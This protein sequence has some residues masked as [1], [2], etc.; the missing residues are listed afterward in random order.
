MTRTPLRR[1][2]RGLGRLVIVLV[3]P[4]LFLLQ[5]SVFLTTQDTHSIDTGTTRGFY[6]ADP[7]PWAHLPVFLLLALLAW[8][9]AARP[10][11]RAP[12]GT[13]WGL[14]GAVCAAL[15]WLVAGCRMQPI[16]DAAEVLRCA[17]ELL[18]GEPSSLGAA[19][20]LNL[21][22]NN[23]F[24]VAYDMAFLRLFGDGGAVAAM[25]LANVLWFAAAVGFFAAAAARLL[26]TPQRAPAF[27]VLFLLFLPMGLYVTFVYG[28][29]PGLALS[30]VQVWA[31]AHCLNEDGAAAAPGWYAA[32]AV[33]G[34]L[35][36][37]CKQNY[38][39]LSV[40]VGLYLLW[41]ALRGGPRRA[42]APLAAL[43]ALCVL[44]AGGSA[45]TQSAFYA[46][47]GLAPGGGKPVSSWLALGM[48]DIDASE[49]WIGAQEGQAVA[50]L[51]AEQGKAAADAYCRAAIAE[52]LNEFRQDPGLAL[53]FYARKTTSQWNM[54][55]FQSLEGSHD[56]VM[57]PR[58]VRWAE[59]LL[60]VGG[61]LEPLYRALADLA[62]TQLWAWAL[63][64]LV[65]LYRDPRPEQLF[66]YIVFLGGFLFHLVWEAKAQYTVVY[67]FLLLPCAWQGLCAFGRAAADAQ[68]HKPG[69][70]AL[71]RRLWPAAAVPALLLLSGI[72]GQYVSCTRAEAKAQAA[73]YAVWRAEQTP[74]LPEGAHRLLRAA[75][76]ATLSI[77]TADP[78]THLQI[79]GPGTVFW[80]VPLHARLL[81]DSVPQ[82]AACQLLLDPEGA[83]A[84]GMG[85]YEGTVFANQK[86]DPDPNLWP[87]QWLLRDLGGDEWALYI[88]DTDG[89][90]LA[91]T[92]AGEG[93]VTLAE[94]TGAADQRWHIAPAG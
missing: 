14:G 8:R 36:A 53:R 41:Q 27:A 26:G 94:Y 77:D 32:A 72:S 65:L 63:V 86:P 50:T 6:T 83:A 19:G 38:L 61:R 89:R 56:R 21:C 30:A 82:T 67:A 87:Q 76:G 46:G 13:V 54:P 5:Q 1:W 59:E 3:C 69:A 33:C 11:K 60:A 24:P 39:I 74:A 17:R 84:L 52:R 66:F 20:Y 22:P 42:A 81:L 68:R 90:E 85:S 16:K 91:L 28:T 43:A 55:T 35:A 4:V 18:A 45:L 29:L 70:A 75:D 51:Y 78:D 2:E 47:T 25:Q 73:A 49:G 23:L 10:P 62:L 31:L 15:A 92:D 44:Y 71:A 57:R 64:W 7:A 93:A 48:Q 34:A 37:L 12:R 79:S 58:G 40:A 9:L 88:L 80:F